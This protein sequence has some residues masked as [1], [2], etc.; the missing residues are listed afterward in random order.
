VDGLEGQPGGGRGGG[1]RGGLHGG[2]GGQ[3]SGGRRVR[4]VD[5][6][7]GLYVLVLWYAPTAALCLCGV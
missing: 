7:G 3:H 2:D 6:L 1:R 4:F 5:F